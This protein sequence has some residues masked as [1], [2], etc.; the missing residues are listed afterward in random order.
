MIEYSKCTVV[1]IDDATVCAELLG[2]SEVRV[3][4]SKKFLGR[5]TFIDKLKNRLWHSSKT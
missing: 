1:A 2:A 4:F 3:F 5:R